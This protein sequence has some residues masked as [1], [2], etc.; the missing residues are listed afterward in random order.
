MVTDVAKWIRRW[1]EQN[2]GEIAGQ[3]RNRSRESWGILREG[4]V[5]MR[6]PWKISIGVRTGVDGGDG[7]KSRQFSHAI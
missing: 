6:I 3:K 1:K 2:V 5:K 7:P 4:D